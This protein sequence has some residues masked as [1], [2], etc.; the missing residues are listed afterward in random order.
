MRTSKLSKRNKALTIAFHRKAQTKNIRVTRL[1]LSAQIALLRDY[2]IAAQTEIGYV[3]PD[4]SVASSLKISTQKAARQLD[5]RGLSY[6]E[7]SEM[8]LVFS[9]WG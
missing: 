7:F 2:T 8:K 4:A 1:A 5:D 3:G 6:P 9:T